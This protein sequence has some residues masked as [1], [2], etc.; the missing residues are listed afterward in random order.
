MTRDKILKKG[1]GNE[2]REEFLKIQENDI[3]N[4]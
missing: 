3:N 2:I 1:I 4:V